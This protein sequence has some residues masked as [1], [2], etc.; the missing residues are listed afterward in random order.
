L[1][2]VVMTPSRLPRASFW[3]NKRVLVTGH[4]GFKGAWLALWLIELGA[5]VT[6]IS[7]PPQTEPNLFESLGLQERLKSVTCDIRDK[8]G[9]QAAIREAD[10]EIVLHLAAQALVLSSYE[11]PVETCEVNVIGT[12]NLLA[13]LRQCGSFMACVVVTSDKVY[14]NLG[15]GQA[16]TEDQELGGFDPYSASKAACEIAVASFRASYFA[17]GAAIATARAGNV[18]GGGDWAANRII[19]DAIRAWNK[20]EALVIRNP[21][22]IRPWQHVLEPLAGYLVLAESLRQDRKFA[23]AFNLGPLRADCVSVRKLIDLAQEKFGKGETQFP[24]NKTDQHE[25]AVLMLNAGLAANELNIKPRWH[26]ETAVTKTMDWYR[27][28]YQGQAA[29]AL[30]LSDIAAYEQSNVAL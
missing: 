2:K 16:F 20:N 30:C 19:P 27:Q 11:A 24:M 13:A 23:R 5:I 14:R 7:L 6:G 4:T 22:A 1:E 28:F 3:K 12:L 29:T 18:I 25:A 26:L 8:D 10:P 9:L 15:H 17:T 21:D